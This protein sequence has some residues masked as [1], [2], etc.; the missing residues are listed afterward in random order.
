MRILGPNEI[1]EN[2]F[3]CRTAGWII[4]EPNG[5]GYTAKSLLALEVGWLDFQL[6]SLINENH[7]RDWSPLVGDSFNIK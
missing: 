6:L 5:N 2:I 1:Q 3:R 7:I 4:A